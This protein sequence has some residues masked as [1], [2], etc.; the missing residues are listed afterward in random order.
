MSKRK[1]VRT[2]NPMIEMIIGRLHVGQSY[3]VAARSIKKALKRGAWRKIDRAT[4]SNM[5]DD[6]IHCHH[7]NRALYTD[8]M[9][10]SYR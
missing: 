5:I 1:K 7:E 8:V 10:G 9:R 6:A 4:R 2:V 3:L